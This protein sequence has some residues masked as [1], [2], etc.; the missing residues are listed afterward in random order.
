V[1]Y[2]QGTVDIANMALTALGME[3]I[4]GF[5]EK[6]DSAKTMKMYYPIILR[7]LLVEYDW[8][9][10]RRTVDLTEYTPP[11][12]YK[13]Y[14]YSF[15]LPENYIAARRVRPEQYYEIYDND[16]LRCNKVANRN[17]ESLIPGSATE[18][19]ITIQNYVEMTYTSDAQDAM[20]FNPGF[21]QYMAY[22]LATDTGF[23]LTGDPGVVQM[24]TGLANAH[25]V[26]AYVED[27]TIARARFQ[28][29]EKPYWYR[30]RSLYY[31]EL[32]R[33]GGPDATEDFYI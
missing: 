26:I 25:Q 23:F 4:S 19:E 1:N 7:R 32:Y 5:D 27:A 22:S 17:V 2:N 18:T 29:K 20:K 6:N 3:M 13:N 28:P 10:A 31:K 9:F 8:N 16:T 12:S 33:D 15:V 24:V 30:N 14:E 11:D 21:I